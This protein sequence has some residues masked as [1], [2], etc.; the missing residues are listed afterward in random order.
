MNPIFSLIIKQLPKLLPVV[1]TL[2]ERPAAAKSD[3]GRLAAI[4]QSVEWLAER[5]DVLERK[6]KRFTM[7]TLM[8][9]VIALIALVLVLAR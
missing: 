1:K 4:E 8:S 7:L 5:S 6:L 3:N 2:L 9:L